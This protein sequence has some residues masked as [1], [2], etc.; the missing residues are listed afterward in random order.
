MTVFV[1]TD[2]W[3]ML[4]PELS[5]LCELAM[6]AMSR[7]IFVHVCSK[8][9][10]SSHSI[11]RSC[12]PYSNSSSGSSSINDYQCTAGYVNHQSSSCVACR[13]GIL[14]LKKG[15]CSPCLPGGFSLGKQHYETW[16]IYALMESGQDVRR[17]LYQTKRHCISQF[18]L[19]N[20]PFDQRQIQWQPATGP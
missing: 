1:S 14:W 9:A 6:Q 8:N 18:S 15:T 12:P 10:Y 2:R 11:C 7:W 20:F 13:D 16:W 19:S 4:L 3:W 17:K 5:F